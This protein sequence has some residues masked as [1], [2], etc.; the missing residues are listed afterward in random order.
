[1]TVRR[2]TRADATAWRA[3][4]NQT[5]PGLALHW[6]IPGGVKTLTIT[7]V[8][9]LI[10]TPGFVARVYLD[11]TNT[12]HGILLTAPKPIRPNR[13]AADESAA[14][15]ARVLFP[16]PAISAQLFD[17]VTRGLLAD[18][19]GNCQ[20][21]AVPYC[22]GKF[23]RPGP[24]LMDGFFERMRVV[25]A[26]VADDE[27]EPGFRFWIITPTQGLLGLTGI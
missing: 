6:P 4:W 22:W 10:A 21:R 5:V 23:P 17:T 9:T 18:W 3:I 16:R 1:M 27:R 25:N 11:A 20:A 14:E 24:P 26:A 15:E 19:F 2:A 8:R 7:E 12:V 13:L